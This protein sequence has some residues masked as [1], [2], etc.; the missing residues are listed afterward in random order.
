MTEPALAESVKG[1]GRMYRHPVNGALYPSVT[2]V[3]DV[4]AKPWLAGWKAKMVAGYAWDQR[5]ALMKIEDRDAAVDMLKGGPNRARDAA[6]SLGDTLHEYAEAVARGLELPPLTEE[7]APFA[8]VLREFI[9]EYA[10]EFR[11]LEG[12]IFRGGPEDPER[13]AGS[14]DFLA[15]VLGA[16][17]VLG[18]YKTGNNIYDEVALQL[19]ALRRGDELW[20]E[21]T[22]ELGP[23]PEVDACLGV[24]IRPRKLGVHLIDVGDEAYQA[25]LG[26][27][28]AWPWDKD[29]TGAIGP[30]MNPVRLER[31][32]RRP[33]TL[34]RAVGLGS[35]GGSVQ[36]GPRRA[37][38]GWRR[39]T[40][41]RPSRPRRRF[42]GRGSVGGSRGSVCS[43]GLATANWR[44]VG[45]GGNAWECPG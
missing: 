32:L 45:P 4:L 9:S 3:I 27:R 5:F 10:V 25:F 28:R 36:Q 24:H 33:E 23:M 41:R 17:T 22:G 42:P 18:D 43:S 44:R 12:C 1:Y 7:Q 35:V 29:H 26:L 11:V 14:F 6:A 19:A 13:Y 20:D 40:P 39:S 31:E 37:C 2:N 16:F 15:G 38:V 30:R 34:A 21:A 8:A